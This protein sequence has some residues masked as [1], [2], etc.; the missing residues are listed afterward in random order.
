LK[1]RKATDT[2]FWL[3]VD[4]GLAQMIAETE[5]KK[6]E[7]VFYFFLIIGKEKNPMNLRKKIRKNK[8]GVAEELGRTI[9]RK[10]REK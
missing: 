2:F 3:G 7:R 10:K 9:V 8:Q 4:T 5:L 1:T 6:N